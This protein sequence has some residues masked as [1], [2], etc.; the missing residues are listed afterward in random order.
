MAWPATPC[1]HDPVL[2]ETD[3]YNTPLFR[4]FLILIGFYL[5]A[6]RG[7]A[8]PRLFTI[9]NTRDTRSIHL[10]K[11]SPS[12][13]RWLQS[14][15]SYSV[16]WARSRRFYRNVANCTTMFR[17]TFWRPDLLTWSLYG[18]E[19]GIRAPVQPFSPHF[20]RSYHFLILFCAL[21]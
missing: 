1:L 2:C 4:N 13:I 17:P 10:L 3:S 7:R 11:S 12:V 20:F 5:C 14:F 18:W 9:L 19:R 8:S 16:L 6:P 15:L 21:R